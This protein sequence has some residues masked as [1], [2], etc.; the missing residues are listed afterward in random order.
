V[1]DLSLWAL[2]KIKESHDF[3]WQRLGITTIAVLVTVFAG[4]ALFYFRLRWRS[5]YGITETVVGVLIASYRINTRGEFTELVLAVLTASIYLIVRGLD[6]VHQGL[7]KPPLDP[8][9]VASFEWLKKRYPSF[10]AIL[11]VLEPRETPRDVSTVQKNHKTED[12]N[13]E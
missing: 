7:V 9:A 8:I 1:K 10:I 12:K 11:K 13:T 2:E 4:I 6:N 5:L 3:P